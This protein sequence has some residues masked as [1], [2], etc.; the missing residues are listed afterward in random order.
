MLVHFRTNKATTLKFVSFCWL[1]STS[2]MECSQIRNYEWER[3][4]KS[5]STG[6]TEKRYKTYRKTVDHGTITNQ[7]GKV[8]TRTMENEMIKEMWRGEQLR[9]KGTINRQFNNSTR[10]IQHQQWSD[11][12][13]KR[14]DA[15]VL[16]VK[17]NKGETGVQQK[18]GRIIHTVND[19][20]GNRK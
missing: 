6:K 15:Y 13:Y 7:I 8:N 2:S 1:T 9:K 14:C 5:P 16:S 4:E 20:V 17:R 10:A 19:Y 18:T 12:G 11:E 3:E